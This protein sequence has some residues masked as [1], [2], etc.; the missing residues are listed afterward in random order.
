M[1][2]PYNP[3]MYFSDA[4]EEIA[5]ASNKTPEEVR[6]MF[7]YGI[8]YDV[9]VRVLSEYDIKNLL[10]DTS[11]AVQRDLELIYKNISYVKRKSPRKDRDKADQKPDDIQSGE[12][13]IVQSLHVDEY[14]AVDAPKGL[15]QYLHERY[16]TDLFVFINQFNLVTKYKHCS[17]RT[18]KNFTREIVVHF[19]IYDKDGNYLY[20]DAVKV[21]FNRRTNHIDQIILHNF[22]V[23]ADYIASHV[24]KR[25]PLV[26]ATS[27]P[28]P[29]SPRQNPRF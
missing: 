13:P 1:I 23:I 20:G 10:Y 2:I 28:A 22:P 17:D 14:I 8:A 3:Y 4:D 9:S 24:P 18:I 6:R 19:S 12:T 29:G 16:G 7:R 25:P 27:S 11:R 26:P 15:L 5:Q 21:L